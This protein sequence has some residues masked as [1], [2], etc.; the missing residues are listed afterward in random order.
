MRS[1]T[2]GLAALVV[3]MSCVFCMPAVPAQAAVI[4]EVISLS[5]GD[6]QTREFVL[7]DVFD[8]QTPGPAQSYLI[9]C[10][11]DNETKAGKLTISLSTSAKKTF[12]SLVKY[13]LLGLG[14]GLGGTP[15]FINVDATTPWKPKAVVTLNTTFG[16]AFVSAIINDITGDV[17]LPAPFTIVFKLS[18]AQ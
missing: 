18:V 12:G 10:S 16:I 3:M 7:Y 13:S 15:Q 6:N 8:I 14:Y 4:N 9:I 1:K 5:P 2:K 17:E 11:G